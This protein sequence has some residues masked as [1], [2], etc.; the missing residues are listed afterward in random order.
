MTTQ[1]SAKAER[2]AQVNVDTLMKKAQEWAGLSDFGDPWFLEPLGHL[3]HFINDEAG[4]T[5]EDATP[6]LGIINNLADRLKLVD[7]LKRHPKVREEQL[8][9]SGVIIGLPRG[10]STLL[11][12][13][14][15]TSPQLTSTYW[16]EMINPVPFPD[17]VPGRPDARIAAGLAAADAIHE[18]WPEMKSVHPIDALGYDE[19]IILIDRSFL[20]LMYPFYFDI[21][22]YSRWY[23]QQDQTKAYEELKVWLQLFQY[24]E[25][26]RRA[27]KWLLKSP[28]HL[29][30]C[31]L[32]TMMNLFP[33][34][35]V[36]MTHRA[37]EKVIPSFC[38]NQTLTMKDSARNFSE[39]RLGPQAIQMFTVALHNLIAV[40]SRCSKDRFID[41]R[42]QD[43]MDDPLG[44]FERV[45]QRMGLTVGPADREAATTWMA[46]NGRDTHPRHRYTAE[47]FGTSDAQIIDAFKF[48]SDALL[49]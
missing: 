16:W 18:A 42:Y 19:E 29:L 14:L 36:I 12:R 49:K 21:P 17:E 43:V 20:S 10:G 35:K 33:D 32:Q 44:Q 8:N 11:Q 46:H 40:R 6:M 47:Q 45:M 1:S 22:G 3:V 28:H 41:V 31:G 7:Y 39:K 24:T 13:L 27:K 23:T 2:G 4:L 9:V 37:M 34:S 26:S 38:S 25:P 48:Y 15:S 5:A 30:S